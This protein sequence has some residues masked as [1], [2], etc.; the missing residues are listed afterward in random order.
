MNKKDSANG[1]WISLTDF[2]VR[3]ERM[4]SEPRAIDHLTEIKVSDTILRVTI[5]S[6]KN[7]HT[8]IL[9]AFSLGGDP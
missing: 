2:R 5:L 9:S 7:I 6:R 1:T 4:E 8:E 3:R